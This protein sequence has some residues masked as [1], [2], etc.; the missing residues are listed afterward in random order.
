VTHGRSANPKPGYA[1]NGFYLTAEIRYLMP[2]YTIS[3]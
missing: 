2:F 1:A 3:R